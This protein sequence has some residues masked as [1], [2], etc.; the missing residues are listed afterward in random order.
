MLQSGQ[1]TVRGLSWNHSSR[2]QQVDS[3]GSVKSPQA[4]HSGKLKAGRVRRTER[5]DEVGYKD[6]GETG[7][8]MSVQ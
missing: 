8:Q 5:E 6:G 4:A 7:G 2:S 3:E 1:L